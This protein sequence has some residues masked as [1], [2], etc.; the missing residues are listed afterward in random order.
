M[1][2]MIEKM[3]TEFAPNAQSKIPIQCKPKINGS[4]VLITPSATHFFENGRSA[5][6]RVKHGDIESLSIYA[7]QLKHVKHDNVKDVVHGMIREL[8]LVLAERNILMIL[9]IRRVSDSGLYCR[10]PE[11]QEHL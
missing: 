6:K 9:L 5:K 7:N 4:N 10:R 2:Y 3:M 11:F 8:S 1:T